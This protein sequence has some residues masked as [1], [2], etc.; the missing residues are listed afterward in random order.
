[1]LC[2]VEHKVR[3]RANNHRHFRISTLSISGVYQAMRLRAHL[4]FVPLLNHRRV[5]QKLVF[6]DFISADKNH[7]VHKT[8]V[9]SSKGKLISAFC[10][11]LVCLSERGK[12]R[13][14]F[15]RFVNYTH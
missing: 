8:S 12:T 4:H 15:V 14:E 5:A 2:A 1:M 3:T 9:S 13:P 10:A 7:L 11:P 6:E